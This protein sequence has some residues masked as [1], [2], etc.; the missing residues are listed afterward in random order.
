MYYKSTFLYYK[1]TFLYYKCRYL[2]DFKW[3]N[4]WNKY[5]SPED[6]CFGKSITH[7]GPVHNAFLFKGMLL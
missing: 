7:P 3:F 4:D 6:Q 2:V 1:C 5:T